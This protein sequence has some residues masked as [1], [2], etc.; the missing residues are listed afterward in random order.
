ML[1][2]DGARTAVQAVPIVR[3]ASPQ[4]RILGTEFWATEANI[5]GHAGLRGAWFAAPSD[6]NFG[7]FRTRYR[8]RYNRDPYRL[9]SLGYDAVLLAMRIA[10]D[11]PIGRRFPATA[12]CA[13]GPASSA[14]TAPSASAATASPN[15]RSRCAR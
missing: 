9:A 12:R 7:P 8:A 5:G 15:A 13:T 11:W 3:Q 6:A 14:S 2:A 10:A 4:P 1:I